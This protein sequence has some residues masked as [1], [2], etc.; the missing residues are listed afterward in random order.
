MNRVTLPLSRMGARFSPSDIFCR[1]C[2]SEPF[3]TL[4]LAVCGSASLKAIDHRSPVASAQV[5]SAVLLAGLRA[6]G[7]TSVTEPYRSRDHTEL[8]LPA[9][10]AEVSIDG[11]TTGIVGGQQLFASDCKIPGD[12]SSAAFLLVAAALIPKSE[13]I[14]RDVL[15]NPTRVGFLE[16]MRRMGADIAIEISKNSHLGAEEVGEISLRYRED[17]RATT[18][19]EHEIPALIDEIPILALLATAAQGTTVFKRVEELRVKESD[20]LAATVAGLTALGCQARVEAGVSEGVDTCDMRGGGTETGVAAT[21][22][23][24]DL[25]VVG[26]VARTGGEVLETQGDHRLAMT[27]AIAA[28]A[29]DLAVTIPGIESVGVS[30]PTFFDDLKR[31]S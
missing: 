18:V 9:Y 16:V 27:W 20:R 23:G 29:F 10:G 25:H 17:L 19:W 30:Y 1:S 11:L 7:T 14:V 6:R 24:V 13:I 4:P 15:L 2:I 21:T 28:R 3:D 8:L 22:A 5:K 12:P 26:G 31:L